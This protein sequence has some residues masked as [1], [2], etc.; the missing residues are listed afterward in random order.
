MGH[1]M[2]SGTIPFSILSSTEAVREVAGLFSFPIGSLLS[3]IRQECQDV[4]HRN[5][6][7]QFSTLRHA[8]MSNVLLGHQIAG[9]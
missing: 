8:K 1:E 2:I 5:H 6:A 9:I 4:A 3:E 7:D